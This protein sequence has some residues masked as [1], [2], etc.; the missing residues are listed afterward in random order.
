M[1]GWNYSMHEF[2]DPKN[3]FELTAKLE[4]ILYI[5]GN[6]L[7]ITQI[8]Q[9]LQIP[10]QEVER[11]LEELSEQLRQNRGIRIQKEKG[12]YQITTAPEYAQTIEKFL[13]LEVYSSLSQAALEALAIV[14]YKQP[15]TRPGIDAVRG[16]NS[17]GVLRTLVNKGL[18]EE[19]GR[20]EGPG[21]PILY[22]T[23]NEF[24]Q[25]FGLESLENLPAIDLEEEASNG[26]VLKD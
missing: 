18:I 24:L 19:A 20:F 23:T 26:K 13:G 25:Y 22:K 2:T 14:A 3:T 1:I 11:G 17:D 10:P 15:I 4:A 6:P 5:S 7:T 8:S 9:F 21:R 16:V 12:R